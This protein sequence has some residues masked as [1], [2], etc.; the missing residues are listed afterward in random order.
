MNV[1]GPPDTMR[2]YAVQNC[3]PFGT[4]DRIADI[5]PRFLMVY[6][7]GRYAPMQS[8]KWRYLKGT[9]FV[10]CEPQESIEVYIG[11]PLSYL[12]PDSCLAA[13]EEIG[14]LAFS[15]LRT[16]IVPRHMTTVIDHKTFRIETEILKEQSQVSWRRLMQA[17]LTGYARRNW[18]ESF[19]IIQGFNFGAFK[20]LALSFKRTAALPEGMVIEQTEASFRRIV[21]DAGFSGFL[22]G[23]KVEIQNLVQNQSETLDDILYWKQMDP[24]TWAGIEDAGRYANSSSLMVFGADGRLVDP[25]RLDWHKKSFVP[26]PTGDPVEILNLESFFCTGHI[27]YPAWI[28]DDTEDKSEHTALRPLGDGTFEGRYRDLVESNWNIVY[29]DGKVYEY[30]QWYSKQFIDLHTEEGVLLKEYPS[31]KHGEWLLLTDIPLD[32]VQNADELGGSLNAFQIEAE[33]SSVRSV[34]LGSQNMELAVDVPSVLNAMVF[35]DGVKLRPEE[36]TQRVMLG[37]NAVYEGTECSP[38]DIPSEGEVRMQAVLDSAVYGDSTEHVV[39]VYYPAPEYGSPLSEGNLCSLLYQNSKDVLWESIWQSA[40]A[41]D[42]TENAAEA[43]ESLFEHSGILAALS[44]WLSTDAGRVLAELYGVSQ[45]PDAREAARLAQNVRPEHLPA[46]LSGIRESASAEELA[47]LYREFALEDRIA[48]PLAEQ[49]REYVGNRFLLFADG[50][51][52]AVTSDSSGRILIETRNGLVPAEEFV[53]EHFELYCIDLSNTELRTSRLETGKA[54]QSL[55]FNNLRKFSLVEHS[56]IV[57]MFRIEQAADQAVLKNRDS[58]DRLSVAPMPNPAAESGM[59]VKSSTY[60]VNNRDTLDNVFVRGS[61]PVRAFVNPSL[62]VERI[63][64][65][66]VENVETLIWK[67]VGE[68]ED[69]YEVEWQALHAFPLFYDGTD[70]DEEGLVITGTEEIQYDIYTNATYISKYVPETWDIKIYATVRENPDCF[71]PSEL[72]P[73]SK[74]RYYSGWNSRLIFFNF[75]EGKDVYVVETLDRSMEGSIGNTDWVYWLEKEFNKK[76]TLVFDNNG[77]VMH[78]YGLEWCDGGFVW[79]HKGTWVAQPQEAEFPAVVTELVPDNVKSALVMDL[80]LDDRVGYSGSIGDI[81]DACLESDVATDPRT[82]FT[83][84]WANIANRDRIYWEEGEFLYWNGWL[85]DDDVFDPEHCFV[86][87][88][89]FK[90]PDNVWVWNES[91]NLLEIPAEEYQMVTRIILERKERVLDSWIHEDE[92]S[93]NLI[94]PDERAVRDF[95]ETEGGR[96]FVQTAWVTWIDEDGFPHQ[97]LKED[98]V[99]NPMLLAD[100]PDPREGIIWPVY[101][102]KYKFYTEEIKA[103]EGRINVYGYLGHPLFKYVQAFV[104]G[105][106]VDCEFGDGWFAVPGWEEAKTIEAYVF[107]LNDGVWIDAFDASG[108]SF[109][110]NSIRDMKVC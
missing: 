82:N 75:E 53:P 31:E 3:R 17:G 64:K 15:N 47:D 52:S 26:W 7:D 72:V 63:T 37:E 95:Q 48:P 89:G 36:W 67:A 104:D 92:Y 60:T 22:N 102:I 29:V 6:I 27:Y 12:M 110:L 21:Q 91:E 96:V 4:V 79:P 86:F 109:D 58:V 98:I 8:R 73:P 32:N 93:L 62:Y 74:W 81:A 56:D 108:A 20:N 66:N 18:I 80:C 46:F 94:D 2:L 85:R 11:N 14:A 99:G 13:P 42:G 5:D 16:N 59:S 1:Y 28:Y 70:E 23:R 65:I 84:P 49:F 105:R 97:G 87:V 78:P 34:V 83:R 41:V 25:F 40:C 68:G 51:Q 44:E 19:H 45:N 100:H 10:E 106:R 77:F 43:L 101:R 24:R 55:Q 54:Y 61:I 71:Y 90:I 9:F 69:P 30:D 50:L 103:S 88:N 76:S 107:E 33:R 38:D 35:V 57:S 39:A